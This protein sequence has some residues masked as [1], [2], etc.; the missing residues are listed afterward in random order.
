VFEVGFGEIVLIGV[1]ALL[2][3]GPHR[4]PMAAR[5]VGLWIGRLR[6]QWEAVKHDLETELQA[7]ELR[8]NL[9][10]V[11]TAAAQTETELKRTVEHV[12]APY[13]AST[14]PVTETPAPDS[15]KPQALAQN[16]VSS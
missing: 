11:R 4:L 14:P 8:R 3:L 13:P 7:E 6:R 2:V 15:T 12:N 5:F 10:S 1:I 9:Q 16:S